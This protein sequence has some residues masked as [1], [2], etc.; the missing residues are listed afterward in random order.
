MNLERAHKTE[1]KSS[2]K[3]LSRTGKFNT[4]SRASL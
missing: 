2:G 4:S 1:E 3:Y